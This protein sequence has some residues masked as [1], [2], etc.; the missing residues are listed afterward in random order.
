MQLPQKTF[1]KT[2]CVLYESDFDVTSQVKL[3]RIMEFMQNIA[4]DH[5]DAL[6]IGWDRLHS[7]GLFWVLTKIKIVFDR[8][9]DRSIREFT[10]YTWPVKA[11]RLYAERRFAA[12]DANGERLFCSSSYWMMLET[13]SRKIASQQ[14]LQTLYN[15]DFD[16][17]PSGCDGTFERIRD[18]GW[19]GSCYPREIRR[20]DLDINNH[21]NNTN[22]VNFALDALS[23]KDSVSA[24]EIVYHRELKFRDVIRVL[25]HR[26]DNDLIV[27]AER[28]EHRIFFGEHDEICFTAKLTLR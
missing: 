21:V 3:H 25:S 15:L 13:E 12:V 7:L 28:D 20:S 14:T 23:P 6:G 24:V 10:L 9:V 8:P 5:A 2:Q 18:E 22:Y 4:T 16:D 1:M 27:L 19:F 26:R 11:N 17:A